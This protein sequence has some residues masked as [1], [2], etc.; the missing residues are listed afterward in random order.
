MAFDVSALLPEA[1]E[2]LLDRAAGKL[3]DHLAAA[4]EPFLSAAQWAALANREL[5]GGRPGAPEWPFALRGSAE[6]ALA[7]RTERLLAAGDLDG[8][9]AL[10][11]RARA[12]GLQV[13]ASPAGATAR[14]SV[15]QE[16]LAAVRRAVDADGDGEVKKAALDTL[17]LA[18]ELGIEPDLDRAQE[19]VYDTV[20]SSDRPDLADLAESLGLSPALFEAR[21]QD[22]VRTS[23]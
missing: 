7:H 17:A 6:A 18:R 15:S 2:A 20:R 4:A 14:Q 9:V 3:A 5:A 12:L 8:A 22:E 11:R 23:A 16:V 21:P 1:A 10:G 19:L 13:L